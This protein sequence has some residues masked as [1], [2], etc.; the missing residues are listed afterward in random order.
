MSTQVDIDQFSESFEKGISTAPVKIDVTK[1]VC[2]N[3]CILYISKTLWSEIFGIFANL[4]I[5]MKIYVTKLSLQQ[6]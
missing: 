3:A 6:L 2:I 1:K 4:M 5:I